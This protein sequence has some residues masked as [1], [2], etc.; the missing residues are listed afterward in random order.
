MVSFI[1]ELIVLLVCSNMKHGDL[2]EISTHVF[3]LKR[4]MFRIFQISF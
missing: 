2:F 3:I 4:G 1:G